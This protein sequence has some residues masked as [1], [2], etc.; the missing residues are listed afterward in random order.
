MKIKDY[1]LHQQFYLYGS[2][3]SYSVFLLT[4]T[5][6]VTFAPTHILLLQKML[7]Y[8]VCLFLI[9]RFNPFK[10]IRNITKKDVEFDRKVAFSSGIFLLLTTTLTEIIYNLM[11][12]LYSSI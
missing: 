11:G 7:K 10:K 5:G 8:Y 2:I 3:L 12:D 6:I 9:I 1:K 4:L